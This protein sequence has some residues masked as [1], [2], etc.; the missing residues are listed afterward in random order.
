[1]RLLST[2][3]ATTLAVSPVA[4]RAE[5]PRTDTIESVLRIADAEL[6]LEKMPSWVATPDNK[7]DEVGIETMKV[8]RMVASLP[9]AEVRKVI[10]RFLARNE[11]TGHEVEGWGKLYVLNRCYFAVP[12][13]E[14]RSEVK[15][16]AGWSVPVDEEWVHVLWPLEMTP[17]G[18]LRLARQCACST[19]TGPPYR[20]LAE[21]DFFSKKYGVRKPPEVPTPQVV[22]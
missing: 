11:G 15:F 10:A 7:L 5:K 22:P 8:M 18:E 6:R 3:L 12:E 19:Y 16:F 9:E 20:A 14:R 13:K 1:M 2:I 4:V 17:D 21:F